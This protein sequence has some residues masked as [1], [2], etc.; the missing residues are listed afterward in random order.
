MGRDNH[1]VHVLPVSGVWRLGHGLMTVVELVVITT[2]A[3]HGASSELARETDGQ[4]VVQL[5]LLPV[6]LMELL[7]PLLF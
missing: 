3:T 5:V 7:R 2:H 4:V 6:V 1:H